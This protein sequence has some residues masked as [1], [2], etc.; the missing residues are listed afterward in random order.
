MEIG[1]RRPAIAPPPGDPVDPAFGL[2]VLTPQECDDLLRQ[3]AV[4]RIGFIIDGWPVVLPVNYGF[5]ADD[6]VV[7]TSAH[8]KLAAATRELAQVA[9][10][11]D[12]PVILF[13]SGWSVLTHGVASEIR[14]RAELARLRSLPLDPWP[15]GVKDH[16]I[17][18]RIVQVT[19]RRLADRGRYPDPIT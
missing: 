15:L 7:R 14:D 8:S 19:G 16:W 5:D 3:H 12:S 9:L 17:R 18:I 2:V 10:E 6:L 11:V 13:R 1:E 4:G